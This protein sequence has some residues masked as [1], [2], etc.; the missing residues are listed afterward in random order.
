[1]PVRNRE[2]QE[3]RYYLILLSRH[4]DGLWEFGEAVSNA[5]KEWRKFIDEAEFGPAETL[6]DWESHLSDTWTTEI[7]RN[8]QT[9]IAKGVAPFE[10]RDRYE[11]VM[12]ETLGQARSTHI[13]AAVKQLYANGQTATDG[14]GEV[15][16]MLIRPPA[17]G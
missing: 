1:V 8:L 16:T 10:V 7:A 6:F 5:L 17:G 11:D 2:H 9:L 13:R 15:D 12:G 3:P 4:P 14:K